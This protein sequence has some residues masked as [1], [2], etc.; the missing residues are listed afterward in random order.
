MSESSA[1]PMPLW[2]KW[3][4]ILIGIIALILGIGTIFFPFF[5]G[6]ETFVIFLA[7]LLI[8]TG[9]LK[10]TYSYQYSGF[11]NWLRYLTIIFGIIILVLGIPLIIF[12]TLEDVA[13]NLILFT[14]ILMGVL[15]VLIN[16]QVG[17]QSS[18]R[19]SVFIV[20]G[21]IIVIIILAA[22]V[23]EFL[24]L[25]TYLFFISMGFFLIALDALATGLLRE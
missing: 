21:A 22:W 19:R 2:F 24:V 7:A 1:K 12:S 20:I 9:I 23:A 25:L 11:P 17:T 13:A 10:T 6:A 4:N 15:L 18:S 8:F 14:L 3:A 16:I 5:L